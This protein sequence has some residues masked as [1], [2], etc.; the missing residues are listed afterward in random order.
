MKQKKNTDIVP[1][2]YIE[3]IIYA[4]KLVVVDSH[5]ILIDYFHFYVNKHKKFYF[6]IIIN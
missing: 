5:W 3:L 2:T 4:H 1:S 6:F